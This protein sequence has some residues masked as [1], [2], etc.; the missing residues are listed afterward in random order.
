MGN[1][2]WLASPF[3]SFLWMG[4]WDKDSPYQGTIFM[5]AFFTCSIYSPGTGLGSLADSVLP[6]LCPSQCADRDVGRGQPWQITTWHFTLCPMLNP[7]LTLHPYL[8]SYL[9][10]LVHISCISHIIPGPH[11][12][13]S[14]PRK[15]LSFRLKQKFPYFLPEDYWFFRWGL[16]GGTCEYMINISSY[17]NI[18]TVFK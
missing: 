7:S 12:Y 18:F 10:Q 5:P 15:D 2:A 17:H 3:S 9:V 8:V 16:G 4:L 14:S 13:F 6:V 11:F 1:I